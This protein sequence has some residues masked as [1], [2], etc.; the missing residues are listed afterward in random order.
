MAD[1]LAKKGCSPKLPPEGFIVKGRDG[2]L[3]EGELERAAAWGKTI[4]RA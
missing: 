2:P 3:A 4:S 1:A